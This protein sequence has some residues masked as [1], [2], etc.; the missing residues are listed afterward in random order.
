[1]RNIQPILLK[2]KVDALLAEYPQLKDDE[3]LRLITI[4]SETDCFEILTLL[5]DDIQ[6]FGSVQL[7]IRARI[8][9]LRARLER[10]ERREE[11]YRK[12]AQ[13]MMEAAQ[14]RKAELPEATLSIR[15]G[16]Q[17]V[18]ITDPTFLP[19]AFWR[20]KR[21]PNISLIKDQLKSGSEV[22]GAALSNSPETLSIRTR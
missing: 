1:M 18:R 4:E 3:D 17:G 14:I 21:E 13:Q 5:L 7:A 11:V 2:A 9:D 12:L 10:F 8:D 19:D 6:A 16:Q 20:V 22:P 15:A